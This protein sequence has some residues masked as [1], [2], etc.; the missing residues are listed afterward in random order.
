MHLIICQSANTGHSI[1]LLY[2]SSE[3][4]DSAAAS[5]SLVHMLHGC[6]GLVITLVPHRGSGARTAAP[7]F[8]NCRSVETMLSRFRCGCHALHIDTGRWAGIDR[9]CQVCHSS[10]EVEDEHHFIFECP[11]YNHI[12]TKHTNLFQQTFTVSQFLTKSELNACGGFL[13]E[14]FSCRKCLLSD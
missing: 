5:P 11:A 3:S 2:S 7:S 12:R 6:Y 13:R 4:S 1:M 9:L 10:Q 8:E 14:S